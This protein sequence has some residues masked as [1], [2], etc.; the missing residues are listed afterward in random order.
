MNTLSKALAKSFKS[1]DEWLRSKLTW[2]LVNLIEKY[3]PDALPK[4]QWELL[5]SLDS[6]VLNNIRSF[7]IS[8]LKQ[9]QHH[10]EDF[11]ITDIS[12]IADIWFG[13][14]L[15]DTYTILL[16]RI[17]DDLSYLE[18]GI[19]SIKLQTHQIQKL[20][21]ED[22]D[23]A[24]YTNFHVANTNSTSKGR[25]RYVKSKEKKEI[26]TFDMLLSLLQDLWFT[27]EQSLVKKQLN[28]LSN[29]EKSN[30]YLHL[31]KYEKFDGLDQN[32]LYIEMIKETTYS[33][34]NFSN[35]GKYYRLIFDRNTKEVVDILDH[36]AY[37][38]KYLF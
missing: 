32:N 22:V 26:I 12:S 4:Y 21:T 18:L 25:L 2:D 11:F 5:K 23:E 27:I 36:H 13:D 8:Y 34:M 33:K 9:Q 28:S 35:S 19:E 30:L 37:E 24:T 31:Q 38:K 15:H 16:K 20:I 7:C 17:N 29:N 1:N 6:T 14:R 10:I 3:V